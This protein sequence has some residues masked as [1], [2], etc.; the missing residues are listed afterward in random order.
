MKHQ[1]KP[2][3]WGTEILDS[4]LEVPLK[5]AKGMVAGKRFWFEAKSLQP[6]RLIPMLFQCDIAAAKA[7]RC[8]KEEF[9]VSHKIYCLQRHNTV[10]GKL[11]QLA[12]L[13]P[14][15]PDQLVVMARYSRFSLKLLVLWYMMGPQHMNMSSFS[16]SPEVGSITL[17]A[18]LYFTVVWRKK[19]VTHSSLQQCLKFHLNYIM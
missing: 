9:Y 8:Q 6:L 16:I 15:S 13:S 10:T 3:Y 2:I 4:S 17:P 7:K 1:F 19:K 12:L 5:K 18:C 14:S 11:W